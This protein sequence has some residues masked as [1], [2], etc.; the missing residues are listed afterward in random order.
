MSGAHTDDGPR[1]EGTTMSEGTVCPGDVHRAIMT[2]LARHPV[3]EARHIDIGALGGEV[4]I[5]GEVSSPTERQIVEE[6]ARRFPGVTAVRNLLTV[7]TAAPSPQG[8][9][10]RSPVIR[11]TPQRGA[12]GDS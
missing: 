6:A 1:L 12:A 7:R 4:A 5:Y 3:D 11:R 2:A 9:S 8:T 10:G